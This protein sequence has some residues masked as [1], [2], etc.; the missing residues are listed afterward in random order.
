MPTDNSIF[1][2]RFGSTPE[3]SPSQEELDAFLRS[4]KKSGRKELHGHDTA[5]YADLLRRI[6][7]IEQRAGVKPDLREKM[8]CFVLRHSCFVNLALKSAVEHYKYH[9]H[10][11]AT[12]DFK[13]PTA[14]IMSAAAEMG[15][16]KRREDGA[17]QARLR[18]MVED[19]R[20]ALKV[21]E[22]RRDALIGELSNIA[23]Y[24]RDN[25]FK[26][27]KLCET[28][29][30]VL[31]NAGV[32]R[33]EEAGMIEVVTERLKEN[34]KDY[35]SDGTIPRRDPEVPDDD[36]EHLSN[37]I[38]R[39]FREDVYTLATL[40]EAVH[41]HAHKTAAAIDA[42]L[43]QMGAKNKGGGEETRTFVRLEGILVSLVSDFHFDLKPA[44]SPAGTDRM[45]VLRETRKE[46]LG[47]LF[48]L[49]QRER[50]QRVDRR[51]LVDRRK[52]RDQ[53]YQGPERRGG[54]ERRSRK[55]RR[56]T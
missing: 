36:V 51:K 26:I 12:L 39:L 40:Y 52:S 5:P 27:E 34:L 10:A 16:L 48:E 54:Q 21:L 20:K 15:R 31:V 2:L 7:A 4:P 3:I 37:E 50:R 8:F 35:Q 30:V 6:R 46:M 49:L 14:F 56:K 38:S 18:L 45:E 11:L 13:K 23:R 28:S 32:G 53:N 17:K 55:S 22:K 29:I 19:R 24:V 43:A 42:L 1:G 41:D 47:L 9:A 25:L 33:S 44:A